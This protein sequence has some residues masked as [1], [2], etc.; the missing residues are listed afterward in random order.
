MQIDR[1]NGTR[2]VSELAGVLVYK[3]VRRQRWISPLDGQQ[4]VLG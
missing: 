1:K 4:N 3:H 2:I